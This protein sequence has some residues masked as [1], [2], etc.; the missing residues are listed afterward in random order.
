MT[1]RTEL[2]INKDLGHLAT[3]NSDVDNKHKTSGRV[4]PQ[5]REGVPIKL[6]TACLAHQV[7]GTD[8]YMT[9]KLFKVACLAYEPSKIQYR[10]LILDRTKLIEV[11]RLLIDRVS[12]ILPRCRLFKDLAAYPRRYFDDL[13]AMSEHIQPQPRSKNMLPE[14]VLKPRQLP[15][16]SSK[17]RLLNMK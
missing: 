9:Q 1:P 17:E 11:R 16:L 15:S 10:D 7:K 8:V 5:N 12:S 6:D 2:V 14:I 3:Q 13:M 4:I